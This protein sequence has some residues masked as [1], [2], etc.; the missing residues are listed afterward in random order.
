MKTRGK[1]QTRIGIFIVLMMCLLYGANILYQRA[2]PHS[3]SIAILGYHHLASDQD[4]EQYF[5]HNMW[6]MSLSSFEEQIKLLHSLGYQSVTL[7]DVYAWKQG[8]KELP[9]KSVVITFDDGFYSS[10]LL[11]QPILERYGYTGSVFVIGSQINN[12]RGDYDPSKRQHASLADMQEQSILQYYAHSYDLHHKINGTF[13]IATLN[14][15]QLKKDT[16]LESDVVSTE[17][18]AYPY[19]LYNDVM[20]QVLKENGTKLAFGYN[21]NRKATKEDPSYAMPRFNVNAYTKLDVFRQMM[22]SE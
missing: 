18:Y 5:T 20:Q 1:K 13:K 16:A 21:E 11:A 17:F 8:K 12:K 15:A 10:T 3:D 7:E 14:R 19:G 9:K 22:E 2:Q 6:T 4:K